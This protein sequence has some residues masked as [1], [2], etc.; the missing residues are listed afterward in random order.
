MEE[1]CITEKHVSNKSSLPLSNSKQLLVVIIFSKPKIFI[2]S[3]YTCSSASYV[4]SSAT[5]LR[6]ENVSVVRIV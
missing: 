2:C 5:S 1:N 3:S 6:N 4:W